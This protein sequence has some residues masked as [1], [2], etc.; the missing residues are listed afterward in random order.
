MPRK[1]VSRFPNIAAPQLPGLP[2]LQTVASLQLED[3]AAYTRILLDNVDLSGQDAEDVLLEQAVCRRVYLNETSLRGSQ[4]IDVRFDACALLNAGWEKM[5]FQRVEYLSSRLTGLWL[6]E[7]R[8]EN[9]L[10]YRCQADFALF[11]SAR[12]RDVR[13]EECQL[14]ETSFEGA[15]LTGSIFRNCDLSRA[16]MRGAVLAGVDLRGS[17][18]VGMQIGVKELKGV[19][20]EPRQAVEIATLL[21]VIVEPLEPDS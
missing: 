5:H 14:Q 18:L 21:G 8:L 20:I 3:G 6:I 4:C 19:I 15:D 9:T 17:T 11:W 1:R 10:V 13:F 16:D 7:A 2:E 12:F